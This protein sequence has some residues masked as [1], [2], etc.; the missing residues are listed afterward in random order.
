MTLRLVSI[1]VSASLIAGCEG[2][3]K[4]MMGMGIGATVCGV[5]GGVA[6]KGMG[7]STTTA[8][9]VGLATAALCGWAG[10]E[11]GKMLDERDRKRHAEATT[12]ALET[13]QP[14]VWTSPDTGASGEITVKRTASMP[15]GT[16]SMPTS[17]PATEGVSGPTGTSQTAAQSRLCRTVTQTIVLK[18]GTTKTEDLTACKGPNGWEAA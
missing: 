3:N 9:G 4:Q 11:I 5:G 2:V 6:A 14:Q 8:V 15:A 16:S 17:Q 10:S 18:D 1:V 12:K 13:G 7:A